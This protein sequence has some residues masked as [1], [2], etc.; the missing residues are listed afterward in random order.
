MCTSER[1]SKDELKSAWKLKMHISKQAIRVFSQKTDT[2]SQI[3]MM[4]TLHRRYLC[5][6]SKEL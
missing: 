4:T 1:H 2:E 6:Y 3:N 5:D